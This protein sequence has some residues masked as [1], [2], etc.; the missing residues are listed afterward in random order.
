[1]PR[2]VSSSSQEDSPQKPKAKKSKTSTKPKKSASKPKSTSKNAKTDATSN[3][4]ISAWAKRQ[5]T[6]EGIDGIEDV[7]VLPK[8][9][10]QNV[11]FE[12]DD[13]MGFANMLI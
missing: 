1:M 12:V 4:V 10:V 8:R 9:Q 3:S 5:G 6:A 2:R 7:E 13:G 11:A